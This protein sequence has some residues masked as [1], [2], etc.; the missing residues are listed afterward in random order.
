MAETPQSPLAQATEALKKAQA[1]VEETTKTIKMPTVTKGK[2][3]GKITK[4][5]SIKI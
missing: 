3:K 2:G 1:K 5:K 4:G